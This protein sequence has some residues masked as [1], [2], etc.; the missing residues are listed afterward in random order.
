MAKKITELV[1]DPQT[2]RQAAYELQQRVLDEYSWERITD[3]TEA[4]Y[5]SLLG[6]PAPQRA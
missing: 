6:L 3:K 5:A 4:L 2:E 1:D